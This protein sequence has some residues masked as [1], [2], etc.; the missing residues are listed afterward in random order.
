MDWSKFRKQ[1]LKRVTQGTFLWNY[2][3]IGPAVSEE[4]IF[5]ELLKKFN[6]IAMGTRV[7]DGI[8]FCEQ[9]L[10]RTSQGT[11]LPSLVH[12]G[13]AVWEEKMFKEIVDDGHLTTLKA[14]LEHVVLRWAKR[15][16]MR[17][18]IIKQKLTKKFFFLI[19]SILLYSERCQSILMAI[20]P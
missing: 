8:K 17:N 18:A 16:C 4:K 6:F 11:F 7:F 1:F 15:S 10:K 20:R 14:P 19:L 3:K 12:I 2:F 5:K 9:F 13:P